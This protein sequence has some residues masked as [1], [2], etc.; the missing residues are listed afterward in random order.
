MGDGTG[1]RIAQ[2]ANFVGPVSGGMRQAIDQIGKR[3][4]AAGAERIL[5]VPGKEDSVTETEAGLLVKV[6]SPKITRDYRMIATPWRALRVLERFG[7]TSI[8]VSDKWTLSPAASWARRRGIGSILFSHERLDDMLTGWF[9][10][11]VGVAEGVAALNRHLSKKF[12]VVVTT[13]RYAADEFRNTGARLELVP[14]G[15]DLETFHPSAGHPPAPGSGPLQLC[16]VGRMSR[17]KDP[18]LAVRAAVELH[19]RGVPLELHVYGSGPHEDWLRELAEEAPV[20]FHGHLA[21][22]TEVAAAFARAHVSLSCSPSETFGLAVLE[23]LASGTP[24]VT[25]N[26]GGARELVTAGCGEWDEPEPEDLADAVERLAA[27]IATPDGQDR[28]RAAARAHAETYTWDATVER[29]LALHRELAGP[30]GGGSR[31]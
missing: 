1:L 15:V 24:V 22:R 21:S 4:V 19:R 30:A 5:V 10:R 2:M 27:R 31:R 12:D 6:A 7:P 18:Q 3:Y 13:S 28:V 11:Q 17:E 29:M 20:T 14:L 16:H 8:E 26:R 23:A 9:Q 25:A